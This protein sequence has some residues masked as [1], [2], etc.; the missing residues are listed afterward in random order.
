MAYYFLFPE[1]DSTIYSHT[2]RKEMNAGSDEILEIL[3]E[4]GSTDNLIYPSRVLIQFKNEELQSTISNTIGHSNFQ[5]SASKVNLQLTSADP[6]NL[7]S[8]LNINVFALSQSWDEGTGRYSNLPTSSNGC[9]WKFKNNTTIAHEWRT[10]SFG[11]GSTGSISSLLTQ[12][13]GS[14]YTSRG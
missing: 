10:S 11:V 13:G 3:K 8:T 2:D 9:S 5:A 7:I 6:K 12:G 14:W 1:K 4:K